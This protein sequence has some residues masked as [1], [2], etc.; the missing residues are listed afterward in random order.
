M[1]LLRKNEENIMKLD[2]I[3]VEIV[4]LLKNGRESFSNI[5]KEL[6]LTENTVRARVKKLECEGILDF[7]GVVNPENIPRHQVMIIGV[8]LSSTD[9]FKK[10]E[11][12]SH[13]R[14]VTKTSV[15]T[16]RFDLIIE[17]LFNEDFGLSEFYTQEVARVE[18]VQSLETFV[19]YKGFNQKVPYVL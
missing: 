19:V 8:K 7:Q 4:R 18:G 3:N 9:L 5:A 15:V 12:F 10:G 1:K 16:G 17:V 11:E 13:L 6:N 14:G 2:E